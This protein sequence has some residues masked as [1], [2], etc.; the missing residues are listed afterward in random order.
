MKELTN[1]HTLTQGF[2]NYKSYDGKKDLEKANSRIF[3]PYS[4]WGPDWR[5]S[6]LLTFE[7]LSKLGLKIG[8]SSYLKF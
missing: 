6:G 3:N 1:A 5:I 4:S 7:K 2:F 8:Q